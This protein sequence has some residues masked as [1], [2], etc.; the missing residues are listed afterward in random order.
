MKIQIIYTKEEEEYLQEVEG[1]ILE[2]NNDA[3]N[4]LIIELEVIEDC[5][6]SYTEH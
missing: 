6:D 5:T 3:L 4:D 1:I 2:I